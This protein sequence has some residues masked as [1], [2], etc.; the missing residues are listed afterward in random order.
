MYFA[1]IILGDYIKFNILF[2][3]I[4]MNYNDGHRPSNII[5]NKTAGG[6]P[7]RYRVHR[8]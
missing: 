2:E 4:I 1:H 8:C 3:Y 5:N 6:V 7:R